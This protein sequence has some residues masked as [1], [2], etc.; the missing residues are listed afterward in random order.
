M[1][2]KCFREVS[3]FFKE[4]S[5]PKMRASRDSVEDPFFRRVSSKGRGGSRNSR[6]GYHRIDNQDRDKHCALSA[7]GVDERARITR[8]F[9]AHTT[10]QIE[11]KPA[12]FLH[13]MNIPCFNH[14]RRKCQVRS[15]RCFASNET[16]TCTI[17]I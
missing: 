7:I 16:H 4:F 9:N 12:I 17:R 13:S 10:G 2:I 6:L 14:A 3:L 1:S 8:A 15:V 11:I 5:L